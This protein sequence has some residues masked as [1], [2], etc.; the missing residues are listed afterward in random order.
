[1]IL[2]FTAYYMHQLEL[3]YRSQSNLSLSP[4]STSL[5][6]IIIII[7]IGRETKRNFRTE[8]ICFAF[9]IIIYD[10]ENRK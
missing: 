7:N 4:F 6:D 10:I 5:D 3:R 9:F 1:M 8:L 2:I